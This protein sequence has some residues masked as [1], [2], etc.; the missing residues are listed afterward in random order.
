MS[1]RLRCSACHDL[2]G[3]YEPVVAVQRDG[4]ARGTS[5]LAA[6]D[7]GGVPHCSGM[8]VLTAGGG[9]AG[10]EALLVLSDIAG[11]P[12]QVE[13]LAPDAEFLY[14]PLTVAEPFGLADVRRPEIGLALP[15][16]VAWPL[17]LYELVLL[18]AS[19]FEGL[20]GAPQL[21]GSLPLF[22]RK[23]EVAGHE[24]VIR[25]PLALADQDAEAGERR[26]AVQW[27]DAAAAVRGGILPQDCVVERRECAG[28]PGA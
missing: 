11:R 10:V 22:L 17:P 26:Q 4:R 9:V 20:A 8:R 13:L 15:A 21:T 28:G 24:A 5:L 7:E 6:A 18:T 2:L 25:L 3:L 19:C 1:E 16:A 23:S 27:L 12:V 14:P